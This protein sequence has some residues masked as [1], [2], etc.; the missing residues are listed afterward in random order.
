MFGDIETVFLKAGC[1]SWRVKHPPSIF[2]TDMVEFCCVENCNNRHG[3]FAPI[4]MKLVIQTLFFMIR[5]GVE[6]SKPLYWIITGSSFANKST[7]FNIVLIKNSEL[8]SCHRNCSSRNLRTV[9]MLTKT[10]IRTYFFMI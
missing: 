1:P 3:R 2:R 5:M 7:I 8:F 6:L 4:L 9:A 10:R